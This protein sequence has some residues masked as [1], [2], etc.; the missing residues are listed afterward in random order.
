MIKIGVL[1]VG[2]MG[3][4]HV[5][6]ILELPNHYNLVGCFDKSPDNRKLAMDTFGVTFFDSADELLAQ[7]DA[8]VIALPSFLHKEYGMLAAKHNNHV[9]MEKPIALSSDDGQ[10]LTQA[11]V[12]NNKTLMVGHVE[13]FNPVTVELIKIAQQE[14]IIAIDI[15]R[16]GPYDP[17]ISDTSVIFDLM[18]HDLDIFLNLVDSPITNL[19]VSAVSLKPENDF[20]D[21][22]QSLLTLENGVIATICASRVTEDKIRTIDISTENALIRADLLNKTL[23]I[24]RRANLTGSYGTTATYRQESVVE[25]VVLSNVEPLKAQHMEFCKAIKEARLP[26]ANGETSVKALVLA[27][28]IH[29]MV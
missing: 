2:N 13:R 5:R 24:T 17:R 18:I 16:C 12:Q 3:R 29:A 7:T 14:K 22:V 6:N 23:Q 27:E 19:S 20:V 4:N 26:I 1:G 11:F 21:H 28:K 9:L 10:A 8:V 15:K 25:K